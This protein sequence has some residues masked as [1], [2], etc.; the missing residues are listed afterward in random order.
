MRWLVVV[1]AGTEG[2]GGPVLLPSS[3]QPPPPSDAWESSAHAGGEGDH[4]TGN[5]D[6]RSAKPI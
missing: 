5:H 3:G 2:A 1:H 6:D 4:V